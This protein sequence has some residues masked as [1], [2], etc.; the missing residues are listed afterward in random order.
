M[1][2]S[3]R[4]Q[5]VTNAPCVACCSSSRACGNVRILHLGSHTGSAL[6]TV[7]T[8]ASPRSAFPRFR[9]VP[10]GCGDYRWRGPRLRRAVFLSPP[11]LEDSR[12]YARTRLSEAEERSQV[13]SVTIE[14]VPAPDCNICVAPMTG[15]TD[16][17]AESLPDEALRP[18]N[19]HRADDGLERLSDK[20]LR[21]QAVAQSENCLSPFCLHVSQNFGAAADRHPAVF[22]AVNDMATSFAHR[23]RP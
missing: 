10:S 13:R 14:S 16:D 17:L 2:R 18:P 21:R 7:S 8:A 22:A 3:S 9:S 5:S 20:L 1:L 19:L 4:S 12:E 11:P 6:V 15:Y 23:G